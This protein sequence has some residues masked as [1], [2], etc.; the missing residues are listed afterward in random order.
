MWL[1]AYGSLIFRPGFAF[2]RRV[3]GYV[4]GFERRFWQVS[5]D[6]RGTPESPG[7][8]VTLVS[9]P[10]ARC[11]G[12]AYELSDADF[13]RYVAHLDVR[14]R[15][16][17]D[18]I[19]LPFVAQD[20]QVTGVLSAVAY[21]APAGNPHFGGELPLPE[22]AD[23]IRASSGPSGHNAEYILSLAEALAALDVEDAHVFELAN[24]VSDP[25]AAATD[26]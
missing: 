25:A 20:R 13:E 2:Q 4:E 17:Y 16:G 6:H 7:R 12:V 26:D 8:V 3:R 14:E 18:R 5:T 23:I 21:I 22:L 10:G 11:W 15:N 24:W 9:V 1:F 19:A